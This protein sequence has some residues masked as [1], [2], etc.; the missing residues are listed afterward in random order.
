MQISSLNVA[1][2]AQTSSNNSK[3]EGSPTEEANESAAEKATEQMKTAVAQSTGVGT[4]VDIT[5]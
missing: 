2:Q 3:V 1:H 5:A 4:K